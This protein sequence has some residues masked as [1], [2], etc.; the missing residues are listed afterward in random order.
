MERLERQPHPRPCTGRKPNGGPTTA[1]EIDATAHP[2]EGS[3][4]SRS[5]E[6]PAWPSKNPAEC[7]ARVLR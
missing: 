5:A 4:P 1:D 3:R 6:A 7:A 2:T